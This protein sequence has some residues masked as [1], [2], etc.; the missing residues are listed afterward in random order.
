M[1]KLTLL[2]ANCILVVIIHNC[3][4]FKVKPLYNIPFILF[5]GFFPCKY[6]F[7]HINI[8]FKL[9]IFSKI[10]LVVCYDN[11]YFIFC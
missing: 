8:S 5:Y 3:E 1:F 10:L 11:A 9:Y 6:T 2:K 7:F 4:F